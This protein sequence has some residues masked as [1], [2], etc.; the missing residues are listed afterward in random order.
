MTH[1]T[2][3]NQTSGHCLGTYPGETEADALD[4][5]AREAGY[6]DHGHACKIAGGGDDLIVTATA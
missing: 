2:I 3:S 5:M 1:Y 6:W 4:A